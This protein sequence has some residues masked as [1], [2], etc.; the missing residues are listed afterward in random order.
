MQLAADLLVKTHKEIVI[1]AKKLQEMGAENVFLGWDAWEY[2]LY[3]NRR[4]LDEDEYKFLIE[5]N[6]SSNSLPKFM[7]L[8]TFQNMKSDIWLD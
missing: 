4:R 6:E 3:G 7:Y 5:Q 1:Y 8:L 2:S